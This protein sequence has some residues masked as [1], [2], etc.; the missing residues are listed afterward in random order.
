MIRAKRKWNDVKDEVLGSKA[1]KKEGSDEEG[2]A[3]SESSKTKR[4]P[5]KAAARS[6]TKGPVNGR[7]LL[8]RQSPSKA[9]NYSD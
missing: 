8:G 9:W 7:P 3:S 1:K 6:S 2:E 5:Q 4:K